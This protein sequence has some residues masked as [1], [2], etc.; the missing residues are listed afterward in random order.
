MPIPYTRISP[1][2]LRFACI[3]IRFIDSRYLLK[4]A[5]IA[6]DPILDIDMPKVARRR[7]K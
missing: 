6:F 2:R 1:T 3:D 7:H 4:P 5:A